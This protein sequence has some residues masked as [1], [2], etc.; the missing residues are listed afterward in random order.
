MPIKNVI[1]VHLTSRFKKSFKHLPKEIQKKAVG[2]DQ[3]FRSNAF[4][5]C[6]DTHKLAGELKNY[7]SYSVDY[8]YRVLFRFGANNEAIYFNIGTHEIYRQKYS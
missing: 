4:D 6:L 7:W 2:R 8:H 1:Q 5:P 3:I